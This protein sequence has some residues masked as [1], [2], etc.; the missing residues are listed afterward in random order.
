MG[1]EFLSHN[2][3]FEK[4]K[5]RVAM[6]FPDKYEIGISNLGVRVLYELVNREPDY[7]CDRV[8]APE[9]DFTPEPLY[10]LESKRPLKDFDVVGF[11]YC[12]KNVGNGRYSLS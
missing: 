2:K 1:G 8:Y 6:A 11:S 5:V 12:F 9:K 7:M 3:D 10:A 4:A